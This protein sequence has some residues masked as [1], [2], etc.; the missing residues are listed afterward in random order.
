MIKK[1]E[2]DKKKLIE[3]HIGYNFKNIE[4]LSHA[5]SHP[6]V[7][8]SKF[9]LLEFIG[10]RVLNL[11]ISQFLWKKQTFKTEREYADQLALYSNKKALINVGYSWKL[12]EVIFWQGMKV[13]LP[14]IVA[15]ACEAIIAVIFLESGWS[16]VYEV[17]VREFSQKLQKQ[18][19]IDSK[20]LL[21][22]WAH[23]NSLLFEYKLLDKSGPAHKPIFCVKLQVENHKFEIAKG[24]SK[25]NAEK[26]AALQFLK[27]HA[28]IKI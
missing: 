24:T 6:S 15:D 26:E 21:Q 5:I 3:Q 2:Q 18:K 28:S 10:D 19:F 25:Q 16:T 20:S 22:T 12:N 4:M 7:S 9:E 11:A 23:K 13:N 8:P 14:T 27:K 1:I 17:I